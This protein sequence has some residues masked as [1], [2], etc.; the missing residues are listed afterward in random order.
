VIQQPDR[1][2]A[3]V[4]RESVGFVCA[5]TVREAD[6]EHAM[7]AVREIHAQGERHE[8]VLVRVPEAEPPGFRA[9]TRERRQTREPLPTSGLSLEPAEPLRNDH[10]TRIR[11]MKNP[12]VP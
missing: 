7:C 8:R 1:A 10:G 11:A 12:A 5:L 3:P 4:V 6:L 2:T 9:L